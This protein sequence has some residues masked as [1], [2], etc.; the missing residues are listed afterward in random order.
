M[1]SEVRRRGHVLSA[2]NMP[3]RTRAWRP[4][5]TA[6]A[7]WLFKLSISPR[8]RWPTG[9]CPF[10]CSSGQ[11][12]GRVGVLAA[13]VF[14]DHL[15][16]DVAARGHEVAPSHW[17]RPDYCFSICL[18]SIISLREVFPLQEHRPTR[19]QH[20]HVIGRHLSIQGFDLIRTAYLAENPRPSAPVNTFFR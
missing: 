11:M 1:A 6:T 20:M 8:L 9:L 5:S 10:S 17:C 3:T 4:S 16:G 19:Q 7:R 15:V 14:R 12:T 2:I 13:D 18:H